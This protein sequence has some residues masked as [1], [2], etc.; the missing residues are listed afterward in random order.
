MIKIAVVEDEEECSK[1]M[2]E[3]LSRYGQEKGIEFSVRFFRDGVDF[4]SDYDPQTDAVFMDI[5]MPHMNGMDCALKLRKLDVDVPLVF[6]TSTVQYA[7]KGYEVDAM[8][9]MVK[10]IS[11]FPFSLI[12]DKLVAKITQN[13]QDE[14]YIQGRDYTK[15][16]SARNLYY[17]EVIDHYLIYH[18]TE[19]EYREIGKL[20]DVEAKLLEFDFFRCSNSY[21][22]N[23]RFVQE[24]DEEQVVI[25]KERIFI[26]R[27]RKKDFLVALNE[28]LKK[29]RR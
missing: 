21:L 20:K 3:F 7:V 2:D 17:V 1:R 26:S 16:I 5:K 8:G 23:L 28:F 27:R 29:E 22:V 18:T 19:G 13:P 10:P 14:I 15:R 11:Y 9:Y 12:M 4:I 6:V 24:I 25:G